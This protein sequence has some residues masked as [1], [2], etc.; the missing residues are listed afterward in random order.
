MI[1]GGKF[2]PPAERLAVRKSLIAS[3]AS[4]FLEKISGQQKGREDSSC[5]MPKWSMAFSREANC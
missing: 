2:A 4:V 1:G 5:K 3:I